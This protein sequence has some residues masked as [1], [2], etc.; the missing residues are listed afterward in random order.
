MAL[1]GRYYDWAS[2]EHIS[3]FE[4][5]TCTYK[6]KK[7]FSIRFRLRPTRQHKQLIEKYNKVKESV[8][9]PQN[10]PIKKSTSK[11]KE[12]QVTK[13]AFYDDLARKKSGTKYKSL[14]APAVN[15]DVV[16]LEFRHCTCIHD[17]HVYTRNLQ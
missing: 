12:T 13:E 5:C 10:N 11:N 3:Q 1:Y 15:H 14:V 2:V 6:P 4:K 8:H 17:I 7:V 16:A 9:N